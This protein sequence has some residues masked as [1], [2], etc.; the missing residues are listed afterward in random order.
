MA[1]VTAGCNEKADLIADLELTQ[2]ISV[3]TDD[4]TYVSSEQA[5]EIAEA[6]FGRQTGMIVTKSSPDALRKNVSIETL[7]DYDNPSMY[8][9]NYSGGGWAIIGASRNYYP[10]LAYNETGSFESDHEIGGLTI[11]MEETKDAIRTSDTFD[12]STKLA[13]RS[14]WKSYEM[15]DYQPPVS[16]QLKSSSD[17]YTAYETR[18]NELY[19]QYGD[20]GWY[21]TSLENAQSYFWVTGQWAA[22]VNEAYSMGS[23]P[24]YTIVGI[25]DSYTSQ[26]V[27]PL[28]TTKWGQ[29]APFNSICCS[30]NIPAG[31][32]SV[33]MSQIMKYHQY[34]H[35]FSYNG[36]QFGWSNINSNPTGHFDIYN[37]I[38]STGHAANTTYW[39]SGSWALPGNVADGLRVPFGYTVTRANHNYSTVESQL[40]VH[41]RPV[42]MAGGTLNLPNVLALIGNGH[43]WVCEGANR[44]KDESFFFIEYQPSWPGGVFSVTHGSPSYPELLRSVHYLYFYMNWGW[45]GSSDGWFAFNNVSPPD[46]DNYQYGREDLY[47]SCPNCPH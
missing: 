33:A 30:S 29:N 44:I 18:R 9:L 26:Q 3:I 41:K 37:L 7:R 42:L 23:Q 13:M 35:S 11:W 6:F 25:K 39:S 5:I 36:Y 38:A 22:F 17:Q 47:I 2:E 19:E 24:Q 15:E 16:S 21:F 46:G 4:E 27:G 8:I 43:Y 31:C 40:L 14:M 28:L 45:Q 10:I 12:D 34:P 1:I 32:A 20:D